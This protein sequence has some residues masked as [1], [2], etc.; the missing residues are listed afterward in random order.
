MLR[1]EHDRVQTRRLSFFVV[2]HRDLALAV[3]AQIAQDPFLADF[4]QPSAEPV[5]QRDRIRHKLLRLPAREP[6]HQALVP[7]AHIQR[8]VSSVVML[9]GLQRQIHAHSDVRGLL[10]QRREN[11]AGI[12]VEAVLRAGVADLPDRFPGDG[13]IIHLRG[14]SDLAHQ[15]D[16]SGGGAGLTGDTAHGVL[17]KQSVQDRIRDLVAD[18]VRMSFRDRLRRKQSSFHSS[19]VLLSFSLQYCA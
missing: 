13:L 5:R 3:R 19:F 17:R 10:V 2:F 12:T 6:E 8:L 11:C 1:R 14:G 9:P 7:G 4:R 15:D 16:Q 18:L